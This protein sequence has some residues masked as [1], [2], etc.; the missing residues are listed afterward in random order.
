MSPRRSPAFAQRWVAPLAIAASA[1]AFTPPAAAEQGEAG[2]VAAEVAF[3][4][5]KYDAA[6]KEAEAVIKA[7][8][9]TRDQLQRAY[10]VLSVALASVGQDDKARDAFVLLLTVDPEYKL[11]RKLGPKVEQPFLEAKGFWRTQPSTPGVDVTAEPRRSDGGTIRVK[12]RDPSKV[13]KRAEVGYRWG[14]TGKYT[15]DTLSSGEQ[16]LL[17]VSRPPDSAVRF[18]YYAQAFDGQDNVIFELG[19]PTAP[20]STSISPVKKEAPVTG[21]TGPRTTEGDSKSVFASPVFWVITGVIVAGAV[22]GGAIYFAT[23]KDTV[24]TSATF[25]PVLV[26]GEKGCR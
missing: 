11:D 3:S 9:L 13:V 25:G 18:D 14:G 24:P 7:G 12:M 17:S 15:T 20:Q 4:S 5:L 1:F 8:K 2:V 21:P 23:R 10:R 22:A 6:I 26:C 19:N 16:R